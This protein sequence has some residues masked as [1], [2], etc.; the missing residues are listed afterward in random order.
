MDVLDLFSGIGGFSLGLERAGMKTV[1]LCEIDPYC[2]AV[3]RKHWPKVPIYEDVR[4]LAASRL[5][6]D[7]IEPDVICGGFP[8]QD[9]SIANTSGDRRGIEGARTGLW[10]EI[11]R[12]AADFRDCIILLENV[13]GLLSAGFGQVLGDLAALGLDAEWRCIPA[14]K[15]GLPHLRDRLWI[16]AYPLGSRLSRSLEGQSLLESAEASLPIVGDEASRTWRALDRDL[17]GLRGGD[18]ISVA[19]ERRRIGPLGNA[20]CPQIPEA[21]GYAIQAF[22]KTEQG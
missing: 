9:A 18:G 3:L 2:R 12:L 10:S 22:L 20:V 21:I 7:G 17:L 13:P 5:R 16:V 4:E 19:M 11:K 1:A 6:A 14:R 8:C 15:A